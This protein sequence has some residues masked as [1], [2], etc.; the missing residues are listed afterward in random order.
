[1]FVCTTN[2]LIIS[3][4]WG[5]LFGLRLLGLPMLR[6]GLGLS[7]RDEGESRLLWKP[8]PLKPVILYPLTPKPRPQSLE[9]ALP[10]APGD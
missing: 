5:V 8:K 7:F 2:E 4:V 1:M 3:V 6:P 10:A 9:P